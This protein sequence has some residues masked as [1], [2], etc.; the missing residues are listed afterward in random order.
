MAN[1]SKED[2]QYIASQVHPYLLELVKANGLDVDTIEVVEDT[3]GIT[4]LPAYDNRGGTKK[5]VRVP[6]ST[7]A[8]PAQDAADALDESIAKANEAATNANTAADKA[9]A[10]V[11]EINGIKGD[12]EQAVTDAQ[13]AVEDANGALDT[14]NGKI[15]EIN[16]SESERQTAEQSRVDA[17]QSRVSEF[18][19]LKVEIRT[20]IT[21]SQSATDNANDTA[22][23]PTYIGE[24]HYVYKWNKQSKTYDKTDINVKGEAFSIKKVW[25]SVAE[26][27]SDTASYK[28]GDFGLVN[29]GDVEDPDNAKLYVY[30]DGSWEYLVDM[31][32]AIGFTGKTPQ[33]TIGEVSK[34]DDAVATITDDGTDENGNPKYR[35]NLVLPKGDKGDDGLE[36]ILEIGSVTTIEPETEAKAELVENGISDNGNPKYLLNLSI[37]RGKK[38]ENGEGAGNVLVSTDGLVSGKIYLFK[39][40]QDNSAEGTFVEY[41]IPEIDTSKLATK[42]ELDGKVDKVEGKQL[43]TED[44]TTLLKQKLDGLS[45]YDDSTIQETVAKLRSD[46]DTLVS[47][48]TTIAIQ[49]FNDIVA[50]LEGLEDTE[51]L[52]SIIASIEQQIASKQDAIA[53]LETIRQGASLGATAIQEHQDI[54]G[55]LPKKEASETY[56]PKGNYATTEQI[57]TKSDGDGTK[58]LADDGTYKEIAVPEV[59]FSELA[60]KEELEGKQDKVMIVDHGTDDT[61]FALTPN[62]LHKWGTVTSL[63]LTLADASNTSVANYYMVEFKSG[64]TATSLSVPDT[65]TWSSVPNIES[66]KTYQISILNNL[67]VIGGF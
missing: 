45:N 29:T 18:D 7:F 8:K 15:D 63:T 16:L 50:F 41:E 13:K 67:G 19:A 20:A 3:D 48:D 64:T 36:P 10:S 66:G 21:D 24:D 59:D 44:F 52:L 5:V 62:V 53:D 46:F 60:T 49:S 56:Q 11:E 31:S 14:V 6:L 37:P 25:S 12:I 47:G 22:N 42:E 38:G 1:Y 40:N 9:N 65:I 32:G 33:F 26:M 54:S 28:E 23:H 17:E 2:L 39:P 30:Q 61:T 4:S 43:S 55:L 51:D 35:L 34:G 58:Y 27:G 57:I